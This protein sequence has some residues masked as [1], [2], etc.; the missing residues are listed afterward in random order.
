MLNPATLVVS[1]CSNS[2][3]ERSQRY[4]AGPYEA[5]FFARELQIIAGFEPNLPADNHDPGA[6]YGV[7][8]VIQG[9]EVV[10]TQG[11]SPYDLVIGDTYELTMEARGQYIKTYRRSVE[12]QQERVLVSSFS[13]EFYQCGQANRSHSGR[14]TDSAFA[15]GFS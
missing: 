9:F 8:P 2:G 4:G 3:K 1:H 10:G 15:S 7:K 13:F 14:F 6:F 11:L 5:D 12:H